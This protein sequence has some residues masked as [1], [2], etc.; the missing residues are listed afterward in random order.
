MAANGKANGTLPQLTPP[1]TVVGNLNLAARPQL[2]TVTENASENYRVGVS[3]AS[4]TVVVVAA[5]IATISFAGLIQP[6]GG[7]Q[8]SGNDV[9][10]AVLVHSRAFQVYF[11]FLSLAMFTSL[12]VVLSLVSWVPMRWRGTAT[13]WEANMQIIWVASSFILI[14]FLAA[15]Y[16][17]AGPMLRHVS[18]GL[19]AAGCV[20]I[21]VVFFTLWMCCIL[22]RRREIE[23]SWRDI[24]R[25]EGSVMTL[26]Y[27]FVVPA[28]GRT[29]LDAPDQAREEV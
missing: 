11:I 17:V 23:R 18:V 16:I 21:V 22:R 1:T 24:R 10:S 8:T 6:P 2:V 5:L 4:N 13:L 20:V 25:G 12:A 27:W 19:M 7:I 28:Y 14:A 9:G 3:Q 29:D 26:F 15:S